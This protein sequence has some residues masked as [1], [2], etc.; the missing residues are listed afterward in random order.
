MILFLEVVDDCLHSHET[1]ISCIS[2][3]VNVRVVLVT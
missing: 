1:N 3:F 2:S